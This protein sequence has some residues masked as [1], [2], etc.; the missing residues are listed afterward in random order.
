M[1]WTERIPPLSQNGESSGW[2]RITAKWVMGEG[3]VMC[4]R[5][6]EGGRRS[7]HTLYDK[8]GKRRA[9]FFGG[10][11]VLVFGFLGGGIIN[12]SL[13]GEGR[14]RRPV[15]SSSHP[16]Y[17][18]SLTK[19]VTPPLVFRYGNAVPWT[20]AHYSI[21][22]DSL[23]PSQRR[24][25]RLKGIHPMAAIQI[26]IRSTTARH[27]TARSPYVVPPSRPVPT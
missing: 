19:Y 16:N 15:A 3:A 4:E 26:T 25:R 2:V 10:V 20:L 21:R 22:L 13:N 27:A 12:G 18:G 9:G 23:R 24:S 11:L 7:Y 6:G 17:R 14:R 5:S 1:D 8:R